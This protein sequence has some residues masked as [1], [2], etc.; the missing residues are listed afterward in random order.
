[1]KYLYRYIAITILSTVATLSYAVADEPTG[2]RFSTLC[3]DYGHILEAEGTATCSFTAVNCSDTNITINDIIAT[4]GC[5]RA[6]YEHSSIA[7]DGEFCLGINFDPTNRPGRFEREIYVYVSDSTE[8][9]V[10]R[11]KGHV[12]PR[13]RTVEEL[14]PFDMGGGLR[15]DANFHAFGYVEEGK[16]VEHSVGYINTSDSEVRLSIE[17]ITPSGYL[18][19]ARESVVAPHATGDIVLRYSNHSEQP[20]YGIA[21]DRMRLY[22]DGEVCSYDLSTHAIMVDNFDMSDDISAP[23]LAISKNIIK[24]GEVNGRNVVLEQSV[25]L[26][27]EGASPLLIRAIECT[28]PA[29]EVKGGTAMSIAPGEET[30]VTLILRSAHIEDWDNPLVGRAMVISNDPLRPMQ[31]IRLTALPL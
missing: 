15:L 5:T 28:T 27:N 4:C 26:K 22:V 16:S 12:Q 13:E 31:T 2:L 25:T 9:I 21:E 11:V 18:D 7:P 30:T 6:S 1:M 17:I 10:L 23:R 19:V 29:V 14:Y 20:Y 3:H 24:F 8:P